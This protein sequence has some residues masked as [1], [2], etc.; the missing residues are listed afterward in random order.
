MFPFFSYLFLFIFSYFI[1]QTATNT[2]KRRF[3]G[4]FR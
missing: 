4:H 2:T 1:F 3:Y